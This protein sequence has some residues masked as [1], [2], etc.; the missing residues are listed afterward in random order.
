MAFQV[1][2]IITTTGFSTVNFDQWPQLS[3]NILVLLMFIGACAGSTGGGIKVSRCAVLFKSVRNEL[4]C[5]MHP[6][7]VRRVHFEGR[8]M[9]QEVLHSIERFFAAYMFVFAASVLLVSLE[10]M[11]FGSTFT[12]VAAT[13]NNIGP[14]L[15]AVGPMENFGGL[16]VLSKYVLMFDMLAGRLEIFPMLVLFM[17]MTWRK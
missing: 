8:P 9:E 3:K 2:S 14:G 7:S 5:A 10:G 1:A 17:P 4:R 6:R 16:S 15:G 13:L 11:D 12:A